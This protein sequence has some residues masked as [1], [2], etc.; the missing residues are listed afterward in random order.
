MTDPGYPIPRAYPSI[1][2]AWDRL[3]AYLGSQFNPDLTRFATL[4]GFLDQEWA[5]LGSRFYERSIGYLYDLTFFHY[6]D[7]KDGF[8]QLVTRFAREHGIT[9]IADVGCGIALDAQALIQAG[10][11]IDGY[12]LDNPSHA[13]A[14]WRLERDLPG[15]H[16]IHPMSRLASRRYPLAYAVDVVGHVNDPAALIELMLRVADYVI[17]NLGPHDARHRYGAADLHPGL[18]HTR[19]LPLL[20]QRATLLTVG[21]SGQSVATLWRSAREP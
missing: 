2:A 15:N 8:F 6:M 1:A 14:R 13:Y 20:Q 3:D 4:R 18:D 9:R 19:I 12:D 17:I 11:D 10:Y 16:H 7:A 21:V 5:S